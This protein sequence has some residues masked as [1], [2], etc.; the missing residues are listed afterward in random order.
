MP[1]RRGADPAIAAAL[2]ALAFALYGA[3]AGFWWA[4]DDFF[5][6][7][8][9]AAH[10]PAE[11]T[12][13]PAVWQGL[14]IRSLTPLL[15]ASL[16]GDLALFGARPEAFYLRQLAALGA[17]AA[18]LFALLRLWLPRLWSAAGA[19]LFLLG[20]A[21]AP[22]AAHLMVRHYVEGLA[23]ALLAALVQV[24]ALRQGRFA[25]A[26][27]AAAL[28]FAAMLAKEVFVP[29]V[30]LLPLLPEASWRRRLRLFAPHAAALALYVAYRAWMLGRLVGS[31]GW[32]VP[33]G[34]RGAVLAA[35]PLRLAEALAGPGAGGWAALVVTLAAAA[36]LAFRS[37]R[38]AAFLAAAALLLVAPLLPVAAV[39]ESRYA[40]VPWAALAIAAAVGGARLARRGPVARRAAWAALAVTL[41]AAFIGHRAAWDDMAGRMRRLA[42]ENR[43]FVTLGPG[44]LLAHPA[45]RP[46][47]LD[48]L[49]AFA[50]RFHGRGATAGRFADD[51][52][53]CLGGADGRR[54]WRWDEAAGALR[55][56]TAEVPARRRAFCREIDWRAPLA[57]RLDP[58]EDA[59]WW[60]LG[61]YQEGEYRLL[62][63]GGVRAIEVPR[64]G[65]YRL[66]GSAPVR[67]RVGYRAPAGWSTYSPELTVEPRSGRPVAWQ[68]E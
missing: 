45:E 49:P 21:V 19:A 3:A 44:N 40:G 36:W 50:A 32:A 6:L 4:H 52:F 62:L 41:A 7:E 53:L 60:S 63:G 22:F 51:L 57:V 34:E 38:A 16:D 58:R 15:M 11:Y 1:P 24:L 68:R 35:L 64:E 17:A 65:G 55:E 48:A 13:E 42:V 33:E 2:V 14:P 28:G 59:V 46:A 56:V 18:A 27:P 9:V 5:Q 23:L 67:L 8:F 26:V 54:V 39:F 43:A 31:M 47:A 25:L 61:P 12:L 30:L 20:P 66:L 37:W 29:L 10:G